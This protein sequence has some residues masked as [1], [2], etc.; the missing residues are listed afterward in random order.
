MFG[1]SGCAG[2]I[3]LASAL[4][5]RLNRLSGSSFQLGDNGQKQGGRGFNET[6]PE[7]RMRLISDYRELSTLVRD[8]EHRGETH[9]MKQELITEPP[10]AKRTLGGGLWF[11]YFGKGALRVGGAL[12]PF[13]GVP[14]AVIETIWDGLDEAAQDRAALCLAARVNELG[15]RIDAAAAESANFLDLAKN[16]YLVVR[17]TQQEEKLRAAANILANALLK[18]GDPDKLQFTELDHFTRCLESVSLGSIQV[19]G[20]AIEYAKT[21]RKR[22]EAEVVKVDFK[23]LREQFPIDSH[24]LMGLVGELVAFN[25]LFSRGTGNTSFENDIYWSLGIE[26]TPLGYRFSE[27]ILEPGP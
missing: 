24:L 5:S 20:K 1:M 8:G 6:T 19:L 11:K 27:Y 15:E 23:W 22:V 14:A 26:T 16:C 10:K 12:S 7:M 25:L 2:R 9:H 17:R 3:G 21:Q 13:F 4:V 18:S